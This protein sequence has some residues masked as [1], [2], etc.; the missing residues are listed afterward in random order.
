LILFH[1]G[2][3]IFYTSSVY[4]RI[5]FLNMKRNYIGENIRIYRERAKLTQQQLADKVGVSWEMISRYE[6]STSSPLKK[7]QKITKAL[8]VS[9]SQLLQEHIPEGLL[10]NDLRVSLFTQIPSPARFD[11][12]QTNY[13]YFCPEW[14]AKNYENVIAI[15]G[16]LV[17]SQI[18]DVKNSV[19]FLSTDTPIKTDD[20]ILVR[21][22][23]SL[24]LK[25]YARDSKEDILGKLLAQEIR[26]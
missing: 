9:E 19:F 10:Q 21:G 24:E 17:T 18:V 4:N 6:R 22:Y 5:E 8:G 25:K 11:P 20:Y 15:D 12:L 7:I 13:Y 26:Y 1:K 2:E 14:V 16:S 3:L 23:D